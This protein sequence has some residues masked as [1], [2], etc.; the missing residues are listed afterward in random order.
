M[1]LIVTKGFKDVYE[2]GRG[3]RPEIYNIKYKKPVPLIKR[4]DVYEVEERILADGSVDK[5]INF[6]QLDQV[7]EQID[8]NNYDSVAIC[9]LHSYK[10]PDH[11]LEVAEYLKCQLPQLSISLSHNIVREWREYERTSTTVINGYIAPIVSNYLTILEDKI[12]ERGFDKDIFI[13]Q[14]NGGVIS[15]ELAKTQPV[16]TLMSGPVGGTIGSL[17]T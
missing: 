7:I 10:N 3:N 4:R 11:E 9:L 5:Q 8:R 2:I 1:A 14:S 15:S 13:M 12:K 6:E 17:Q 16:Q